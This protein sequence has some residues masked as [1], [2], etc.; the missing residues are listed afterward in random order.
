[1]GDAPPLQD[2]D[3]AQALPPLT[4]LWMA[5]MPYLGARTPMWAATAGMVAEHP[6]RGFGTGSFL[7]E[8]PGFSKR[9]DLF[10]DFETLG[11]RIKTNPHN[12]LLQIASENGIPMTLL[13]AGLYLWLTFRVMQQAW[14][15]PN[16]FWLCGVWALWA[17]GL[18]AQVNHVFFN[19]ASLFMAAVALGLLY[20]RLPVSPAARILALCPLYRWPIIP[21]V[22]SLVSI[23]LALYPL[24]WLVS[25]YYVS[26]AT[27]LESSHP[28]AS[29][30][31]IRLTWEAAKDWSPTNPRA[32]Y[33]LA[34]VHYNTGQLTNA[35]EYLLEFLRLAPNHSAGLNLLAS[36]Y[37]RLGRL[38]EAETTLGKALSLDPDAMTVREN[39]EKIRN[40][41][42]KKQQSPE[43]TP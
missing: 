19:P 16:A 17:A 41:K 6:W 7:F 42:E 39:L 10:R 5:I 37:A 35:E 28:P 1:M 23:V 2:I 12:I 13:F 21:I 20:G 4:P 11:I 9:Y 31:H 8:Y 36:L 26:E 34:I 14:R 29:S 18:D 40:L 30:R 33:G 38:D 25:E 22:T 15:E 27:R 43:T 32:V 24:R 3:K